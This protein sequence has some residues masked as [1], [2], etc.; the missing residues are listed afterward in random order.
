MKSQKDL[1]SAL[2]T[3]FELGQENKLD[4]N[5]PEVKRYAHLK[6]AAKEQDKDFGIVLEFINALKN[7]RVNMAIIS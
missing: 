2:E 7:G 6:N 1:A 5:D 4:K 3:V